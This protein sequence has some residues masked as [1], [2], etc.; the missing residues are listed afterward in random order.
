[1]L[2]GRQQCKLADDGVGGGQLSRHSVIRFRGSEEEEK[3]GLPSSKGG[4]I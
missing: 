3:E 1:L 2:D 4:G